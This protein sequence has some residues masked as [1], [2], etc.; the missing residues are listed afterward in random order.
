[1]LLLFPLVVFILLSLLS[2]F[3]VTSTATTTFAI[4]VDRT[5]IV[6]DNWNLKRFSST[7]YGITSD[8]SGNIYFVEHDGNKIGRLSPATN[9]LTEWVIPTNSSG[10]IGVA[11][12]SSSGNLYFAENNTNKIGRLVLSTNTFTEWAI[13]YNP[14]TIFIDS[15]GSFYFIGGGGILGRL[16]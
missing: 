12:D 16:G 4:P 11:F 7:I 10:P 5:T 6:M 8:F 15:S 2:L 9:T 1:M 3:A 13:G 14:L